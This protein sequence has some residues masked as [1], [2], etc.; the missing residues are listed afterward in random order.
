M[1]SRSGSGT[2]S[3]P[4]KRL[5]STSIPI[6][7]PS[8]TASAGLGER[9]RKR[10]NTISGPHPLEVPIT[11]SDHQLASLIDRLNI[12]NARAAVAEAAAA[13][14]SAKPIPQV[15]LPLACLTGS[16]ESCES[17]DQTDLEEEKTPT[18]EDFTPFN[19]PLR[20]CSPVQE[21][22]SLQPP[23]GRTFSYCGSVRRLSPI[24]DDCSNGA[25]ISSRSSSVSNQF[26]PKTSPIKAHSD[27][28][29]AT[30]AFS[31]DSVTRKVDSA[32]FPLFDPHFPLTKSAQARGAGVEASTTESLINKKSLADKVPI[33]AE[34]TEFSNKDSTLKN[35]AEI[36]ST[37]IPV[38]SNSTFDLSPFEN[39]ILSAKV[40][41]ETFSAGSDISDS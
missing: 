11:R 5:P 16:T 39:S 25:K 8:I 6:S 38:D 34:A 14:L 27:E 41:S 9:R 32:A 29:T 12:Q 31:T 33:R 7:T 21:N 10:S 24:A 3:K 19:P 15:L 13:T 17:G 40:F 23:R 22:K 28:A 30:E 37:N 4:S 20:S 26:S 35:S 1:D 36:T 2:P 18:Q